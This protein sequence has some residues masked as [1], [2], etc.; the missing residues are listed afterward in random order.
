MS[1][2]KGAAFLALFALILCA[3][4]IEAGQRRNQQQQQQQQQAPPPPPPVGP[5]AKSQEEATAFDAV[6][7]DRN[8]NTRVTLADNFLTT[9]PASELTGYIQ[10]FRME[11]LKAVNK[12]K[13]AIAAGEAALAFEIKFMED[14]IK[15]AD[16]EQAAA[17]AAAEANRNTRNRDR[18]APPPPAPLDKNSPEF[19]QFAQETERAL[20]Y[21]YQNLMDSYQ[22]LNDALKTM[23]Y[24]EKALGQDPEDLLTL[25]TLS[26]VMAERPPAT[27]AEQHNKRAEELGKM[28]LQKVNAFLSSPA[29]ANVPQEAK[30]GLSSQ[31]NSTMGLV[32]LNMKKWGD[33]QKAYIAAINAKKDDPV[34]YFRLG[35]SYAQDNK[36]DL[37]MEALAKSVFLKGITE[38]QA[39]DV[40]QQLYE[41]KNKSLEGLDK[42]IADAGAKIGQ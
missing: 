3:S 36:I 17:K 9:Y 21:Y 19:Q 6:R 37:G 30:D 4:V 2:R 16:Q 25:L 32:Y 26:S 10:R 29:A 15:R 42:F 35:L 38:Q 23:E 7:V 41:N 40:L 1:I 27:G 39:R 28:A 22:Q 11:A 34:S 14:L 24:A 20:M 13:E 8:P 31:A 18:N 12:H 33:S 5:K